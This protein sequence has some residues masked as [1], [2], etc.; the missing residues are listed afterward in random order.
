MRLFGLPTQHLGQHGNC[1]R[2]VP[3]SRFFLR[4]T[5][6]FSVIER[7]VF[8]WENLPTSDKKIVCDELC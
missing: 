6:N 2:F 5:E 4:S 3:M 1:E 8:Q 7:S